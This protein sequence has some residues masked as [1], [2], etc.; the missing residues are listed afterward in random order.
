MEL[1]ISTYILGISR[2]D[3]VVLWYLTLLHKRSYS[4][5]Q[6][7]EQW[8]L[9]LHHVRVWITWMRVVPFIW[10]EPEA[11]QTDHYRAEGWGTDIDNF[12]VQRMGKFD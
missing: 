12:H 11:N 10:A 5:P 9:I 6:T 7:I 1:Y 3:K 4:K 2:C 8:E